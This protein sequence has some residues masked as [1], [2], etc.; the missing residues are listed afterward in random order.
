[1][2][3]VPSSSCAGIM[4]FRS[5]H[6]ADRSTSR[7]IPGP[8]LRRGRVRIA[9]EVLLLLL[10]TS[11]PSALL[12]LRLVLVFILFVDPEQLL[13]PVDQLI[14]RWIGKQIRDQ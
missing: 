14:D 6:Y 5:S 3:S 12:L 7:L 9:R 11:V 2:R 8:M 13:G 1:M 10:L 4:R